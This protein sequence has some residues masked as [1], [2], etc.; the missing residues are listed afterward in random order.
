MNG[1]DIFVIAVIA[2]CALVGMKR[3]L[4][5]TC[6]SFFTPVVS[7]VLTSRIYPAFSKFLRET[8]VYGILKK[9]VEKALN[10]QTISE[11]VSSQG[12]DVINGLSIPDFL[13]TSLIENN[14]TVV[15]NILDA[16]GLKEYIAGYIANIFI[17]IVSML[18]VAVIIFIIIKVIFLMLDIITKLPIIHGANSMAGLGIGILHGILIVWIVFTVAVLFVS[19]DK[20]VWFYESLE[21]SRLG[22]FLFKNDILLKMILKIFA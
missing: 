1:I 7:L 11:G 3:G 12:N 16:S 13:K 19:G 6:L 2:V 9:G 20:L 18:I 4:V 15:Y 17:N 5:K 22:M 8:P 21:K 14:N 10:L